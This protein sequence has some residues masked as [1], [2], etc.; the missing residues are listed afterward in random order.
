MLRITRLA[1]VVVGAIGTSVSLLMIP[2]EAVFDIW[3]QIAAI[4]GGGMLGL[5]LL[6]V[7]V[8]RSTSRGAAL[9]V[10][11][12]I[13]VILW[14]ALGSAPKTR[15]LL[16]SFVFPYHKYL[17]GFAGTFA[18]LLIGWMESFLTQGNNGDHE[19]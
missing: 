14:G 5:F 13:L 12:G 3:L 16:G 6:G 2:A 11:A 1:T 8:P 7:L 17:I 15:D 18:I 4:F 9:G 10:L 19:S